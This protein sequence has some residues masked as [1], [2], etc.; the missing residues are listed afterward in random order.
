MW[1]AVTNRFRTFE[2]QL[3]LSEAQTLDGLQKQLG[4]RKALHR[5]YWNDEDED[6]LG[7]IVGSWGKLTA[8]QPPSDVD[9]IMPLPVEHYR[10]FSTYT[11]NGQS[12]LLQEVKDVLTKSY[13]QTKM[14]GDGQVVVIAFNSITIEV[15][16][17]FR[18][19][20][21]GNWI[22]PDTHDGGSW[23]TT[24]HAKETDALDFADSITISCAR[25]FIRMIKAWRDY[26]SVPLKSFV[27]E[28]LVC[29]FLNGY[30]FKTGGY[31]YFDWFCRDFFKFLITKQN[32]YVYAFNNDEL[33]ALGS[34]WL[35]KA[36]KAVQISEDACE[37]ERDDWTALAGA[38][39]QKIF[40]SRIPMTT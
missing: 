15:V 31:F 24:N 34:D 36:K 20:D 1:I 11:S 33:V 9:I 7:Y 28:N 37:Y 23:K 3:N 2:Q 5:A 27:I 12:A 4:V 35:S 14:R 26:C 17:A 6:P 8:I 32:S 29:E 40:G 19:D 18:L 21:H 22:I 30:S 25:P 16:P 10:R 13:A 39:W 38:E